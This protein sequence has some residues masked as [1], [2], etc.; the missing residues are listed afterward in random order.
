MDTNT[1][2]TIFL[3]ACFCGAAALFIYLF[4][5]EKKL[6]SDGKMIHRK[7][8]FVEEAEEFTLSLNNPAAVAEKLRKLS[9]QEMKVTMSSDRDNQSFHFSCSRC[10]WNARLFIKENTEGRITYCFEFLNWQQKGSTVV[11]DLC[12]NLLLTA[13]EKMFLEL[14]PQTEVQTHLL[15]TKTKHSFL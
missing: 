3:I 14:D 15:E 11:G 7:R 10:S 9:Y 5:R 13:I 4:R 6:R 12:M 2:Y 8:G 1:I